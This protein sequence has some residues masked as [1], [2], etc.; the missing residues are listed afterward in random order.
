MAVPIGIL[1][2]IYLEDY[3][4]TE[5]W[6]NRL[7]GLNIQNLAGVPSIVYGILGLAVV[8]RGLGLGRVLLAGAIILTL[9][10]LTTVIIASREA[11]RGVPGS[12][13]EGGFALGA[14]QWQV[15]WRQVLPAALP[16]IATGAI[17]ALPA[18]SGRRPR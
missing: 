11:L 4:N 7:L 15:V 1:T 2:A 6:Y 9:L 13:R 17:L 18:R 16:G 8:V 10:V 3:A 14:T 12:I 5:R